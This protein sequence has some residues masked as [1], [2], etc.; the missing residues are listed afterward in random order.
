M[1]VKIIVVVGGALGM[2]S[3]GGGVKTVGGKERGCD[4]G[5][6]GDYEREIGRAHV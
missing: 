5:R 2:C 3:N 6:V 4:C 1:F